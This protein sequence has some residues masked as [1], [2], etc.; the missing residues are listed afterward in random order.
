MVIFTG[1][2][3]VVASAS[4]GS[5]ATGHGPRSAS[6]KRPVAT[7]YK[8]V[9]PADGIR[10]TGGRK[11]VSAAT[12]TTA[13]RARPADLYLFICAARDRGTGVWFLLLSERAGYCYGPGDAEEIKAGQ[14]KK[15]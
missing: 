8:S 10:R 11:L 4:R 1:L 2:S 6:I 9:R 13:A 14:K 7:A 5:P 3:A 15:I 12:K